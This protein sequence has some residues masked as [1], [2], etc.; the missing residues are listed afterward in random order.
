MG[1]W[2]LCFPDGVGA[3]R[4]HPVQ[5]VVVVRVR[6][7]VLSWVRLLRRVEILRAVQRAL[8]AVEAHVRGW[9]LRQGRGVLGGRDGAP[10]HGEGRLLLLEDGWRLSVHSQAW[11][12]VAAALG[13]SPRSLELAFPNSLDAA[14]AGLS[15]VAA[16]NPTRARNYRARRAE[17]SRAGQEGSGCLLLIGSPARS[18]PLPRGQDS[19]DC[20]LSGSLLLP[21]ETSSKPLLGPAAERINS[22]QA[23]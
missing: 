8:A 13:R 23:P 6:V 15:T 5:V 9:G 4:T 3:A 20:R 14:A 7:H 11:H 1:V 12:R 10:G 19:A 16:P 22:W 21:T 2:V 18:L 17:P